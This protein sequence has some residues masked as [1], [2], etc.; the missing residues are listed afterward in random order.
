M[1][2]KNNDIKNN[3]KTVKKNGKKCI[4]IYNHFKCQLAKCSNQK[5]LD[6]WLDYKTRPVG[7]VTS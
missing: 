4:S 3:K 7:S 6:D 5:T 1:E 2:M